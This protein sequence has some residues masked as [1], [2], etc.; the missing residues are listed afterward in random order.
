[1]NLHL[2]LQTSLIPE[3]TVRS[4]AEKILGV[5]ETVFDIVQ[6]TAVNS[7]YWKKGT[8]K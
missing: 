4:V 1:M 6:G 7:D 5:G 3:P 2:R 8:S